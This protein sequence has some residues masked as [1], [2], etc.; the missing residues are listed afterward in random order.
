[1]NVDNMVSLTVRELITEIIEFPEGCD[2]G[3][4]RFLNHLGYDNEAIES[5]IDPYVDV[6]MLPS[7]LTVTLRWMPDPDSVKQAMK[8]AEVSLVDAEDLLLW[9]ADQ[10]DGLSLGVFW[11]LDVTASPK[12]HAD[13]LKART[14]LSSVTLPHLKNRLPYGYVPT[15]T[16]IEES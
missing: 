10:F 16:T 8:E 3:K 4:K 12:D 6:H 9:L 1:M 5:V 7:T 2:E 11:G 15:P 13:Q 14:P